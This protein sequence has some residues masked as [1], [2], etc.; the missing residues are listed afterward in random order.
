MPPDL[1]HRPKR[2]E[3]QHIDDIFL[4]T[5]RFLSMA[6]QKFGDT[7]QKFLKDCLLQFGVHMFIIAG[8]KDQNGK[9]LRTKYDAR[10]S[11]RHKLCF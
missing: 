6:E 1:I 3:L 8:Y 2:S 9:M 7:V 11:W 10:L 5:W 4:L